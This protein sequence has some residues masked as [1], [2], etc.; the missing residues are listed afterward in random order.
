MKG[1][2]V[3]VPFLDVPV[4]FEI[5][6]MY[7][8][9]Y[10]VLGTLFHNLIILDCLYGDIHVCLT[11]RTELE[12]PIRNVPCQPTNQIMMIIKLLFFRNKAGSGAFLLPSWELKQGMEISGETNSSSTTGSFCPYKPARF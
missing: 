3:V 9:I 7:F 4:R 6:T 1:N 10:N 2:K 12:Q 5:R 11:L 8:I